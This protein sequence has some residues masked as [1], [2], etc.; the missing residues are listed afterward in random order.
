MINVNF[1][2]RDASAQKETPINCK[3]RYSSKTITIATKIKVH[4][5]RWSTVKQRLKGT[6]QIVIENNS[7]LD[8]IT[9]TAK[10]EYQSFINENAFDPDPQQLK[11]LIVSAV[12]GEGNERGVTIPKELFQYIKF[13]VDAQKKTTNPKTGRLI[14][15]R[16]INDYRL[17]SERLRQFEIDTRTQVSFDSIDLEFYR[18]FIGYLES[19][20]FRKNTIGKYI[21]NLKSVLNDATANGINK[22]LKYKSKKFIKPQEETTEIYIPEDQLKELEN[23]DLSYSSSLDNA[24]NLLL[25]LCY[26]GQRYQSLKDVINPLN[27]KN[28]N[29][30]LVQ[31]KENNP[32]VIPIIPPLANILD[33]N[34]L[35]LI[36][37][38]KLNVY[39]KKVCQKVP[40]FNKTY[41]ITFTKGGK[42]ITKNELMYKLVT[43]HS[44]RRSFA[45]N[46]YNRNFPVPLI[47]AITGHEKES[48]FYTYIRTTPAEN[49]NRF[50]EMYLKDIE[51]LK[52]V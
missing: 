49:A 12:F 24:R 5:K 10:I 40:S 34:I 47:M 4:P 42:M 20:N 35:K 1:N 39:V 8:K 51:K 30:T 7:L 38:T 28:G 11:K 21:K 52:I 41:E 46:F 6:L 33:K 43:T 31:G 32:V 19:L 37:N 17:L 23:L 29:I 14:S 45:T 16:T 9:T 3:I 27:R 36:S 44:G 13:F 48:S 26:T 25:V 22:N 2:L 18:D 50:K 15:K